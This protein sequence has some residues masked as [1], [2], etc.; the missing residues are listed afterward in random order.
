MR[1]DHGVEMVYQDLALFGN[2]SVAQN[3]YAGREL[4][5]PS[6]AGRLGLLRERKMAAETRAT[7]ER[8]GVNIPDISVDVAQM[9]G[10]QRQAV[11]VA[12]AVAFVSK[13]VILDEPTAALGMREGARVHDLVR[14]LTRARCVRDP[15]SPTTCRRSPSSPIA[16]VVLRRGAGGGRGGAHRSRTRR[17]SCRS[18]WVRRPALT[19]PLRPPDCAAAAEAGAAPPATRDI[20]SRVLYCHVDASAASWR[21]VARGVS[22]DPR[23]S[24]TQG[25]SARRSGEILEEER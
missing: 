19:A 24:P 13:V 12:R 14:M 5:W 7:L 2:L 25:R 16:P 4:T 17:C 21:R 10:G 9:S 11:A 20:I 15:R 18:S 1:R 8:L 23:P 22:A 6:W 3:F